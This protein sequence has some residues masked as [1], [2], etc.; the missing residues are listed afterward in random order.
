MAIAHDLIIRKL[1]EHSNLGATE[2]AAIRALPQTERHLI[3]NEDVVLQG[4]KPEESV[5]VLQ[6]MVARYHTLRSGR[7]QYL[8]FHI[9]GDMPDSQAI[10][11]DVMDHSVC[12]LGDATVALVPHSALV[13]L[14]KDCPTFAF[15]IWRE[16][17]VDAAIFREAITNNSGRAVDTRLAHLLCEQYY[18]ARASDLGKPGVSWLPLTQTQLGE[19]LGVSLPSIS[20]ALRTLRKTGVVDLE[21]GYLHVH[22]WA[23]LCEL[24]EFDPQYLHLSKVKRL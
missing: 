5:I 16:T 11:I 12:A 20:R 17:L 13:K 21:G 3:A 14:F 23:G 15:A 4:D 24:G 8:A 22:D 1:L 6:G 9:P 18:R 19:A 10:F 2:L 7:R